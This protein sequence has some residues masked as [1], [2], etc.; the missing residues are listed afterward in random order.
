M[1]TVNIDDFME[2]KHI[3][4]IRVGGTTAKGFE[5]SA[6]MWGMGHIQYFP[7][8]PH[9]DFYM[10][11]SDEDGYPHEQW[12]PIEAEFIK[13]KK[14]KNPDYVYENNVSK[15]SD[16]YAGEFEDIPDLPRRRKY[17]YRSNTNNRIPPSKW[18]K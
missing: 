18:K 16:A 4:P 3:Q 7:N 12:K 15:S 17:W 10:W 13:R 1:S 9:L 14:A 8:H 2:E 6:P 5:I 11:F